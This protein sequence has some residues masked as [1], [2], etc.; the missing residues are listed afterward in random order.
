MQE[1]FV[2]QARTKWME[3][4][5]KESDIVI[6]SRV[7]LARNICAVPFPH[8]A[9]EEQLQGVV[10]E[11]EQAINDP[12]V[13]QASGGLV[14]VELQD[15]NPLDRA[16]LVDKHLISPQ[17]AEETRGKGLVLSPDEAVSVLI[18][19]EDHLRVQ[20]IYP[21]LQLEEAWA[22]A[23]RI[24]DVLESKL[25]FAFD[26]KLGYLTACPTNVGTGLRASVMMHLPAL[27]L[28]NQA[29]RALA[30]L[31]Q[32]GMTVR[33]LYGEGTEATGNLFQIS[34][35]VTLGRS[36]EEIIS[37]LM[38]IATQLIDHER[39]ARQVLLK[40]TKDQLEDRVCRAFG[41]LAH[42]RIMTTNEAMT[43]LSNVRLGIDLGIIKG[44]SPRVLNEMLVLTRP[45][46]LQKMAGR[47]LSAFERDVQ[48]ASLIRERFRMEE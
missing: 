20:C 40:E 1:R 23:S 22:L 8:G 19:E 16:V 44:I 7:R 5:G 33:G 18:N 28:T 48:R 41:T 36:E 25:D 4:T 32:L 9:K 34:N 46:F 38:V 29:T 31:S 21:G 10:R 2:N 3:G 14:S 39:M 24:D 6:S 37:N 30:S 17:H 11:V 43:L 27:V 15:L 13:Q 26:E 12:Q 47:E 35:Q 42:A 45:A